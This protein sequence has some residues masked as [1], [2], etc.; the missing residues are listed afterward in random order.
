MRPSRPAV[1]FQAQRDTFLAKP[2]FSKGLGLFKKAGVKCSKAHF[3]SIT[4]LLGEKVEIGTDL[5][6]GTR[7]VRKTRRLLTLVRGQVRPRA[8]AS[9]GGPTQTHG[10]AKT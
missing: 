9:A 2:L 4:F 7:P 10:G 8:D 3:L 1:C 5:S 6:C